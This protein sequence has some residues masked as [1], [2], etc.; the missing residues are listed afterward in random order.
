ML[1][2]GY[3]Y[4]YFLDVVICYRSTYLTYLQTKGFTYS[5]FGG[6]RDEQESTTWYTFTLVG[7]VV[8]WT[9]KLH[10]MVTL[11][12]TKVDYVEAIDIDLWWF[13]DNFK[14]MHGK[15]TL[16]FDS[17][18]D[19]HLVKH[20]TF[21]DHMKTIDTK[22][23]SIRIMVEEGMILLEKIIFYE[24]NVDMLTKSTRMEKFEWCKP[25]RI[26]ENVM[27]QTLGNG[28]W[29]ENTSKE[30]HLYWLQVGEC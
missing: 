22:F 16:H 9:S 4:I 18:T 24:N 23:H 1:W 30:L 12:T 11:S 10:L 21:H 29:V 27:K 2:S 19:I 20:L 15:I 7:E 14:M 5:D 8:S 3:S 17:K 26:F 13:I 28:T 25:S 6:D